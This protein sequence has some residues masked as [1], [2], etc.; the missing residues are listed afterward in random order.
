[1]EGKR[2]PQRERPYPAVSTRVCWT[3]ALANSERTP[4]RSLRTATIGNGRYQDLLLRR[5]FNLF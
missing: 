2:T 1:M 5:S 4:Q 3:D